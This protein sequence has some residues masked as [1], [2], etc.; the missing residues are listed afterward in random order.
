[1]NFSS[2]PTTWLKLKELID[3]AFSET[4]YDSLRALCGVYLVSG[5]GIDPPR[6]PAGSS[7]SH[8]RSIN[9]T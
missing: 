7:F 9:R 3:A 4:F 5:P 1:M 8:R 2:H 6:V